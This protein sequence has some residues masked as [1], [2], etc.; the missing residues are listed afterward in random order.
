MQFIATL[1][2]AFPHA[3]GWRK[4]WRQLLRWGLGFGLRT[5]LFPE[6]YRVQLG[7]V[8]GWIKLGPGGA[9]S[10]FDRAMVIEVASICNASCSFC[11]YPLLEFPRKVMPAAAFA[12][13][14]DTARAAGLQDVDFTPYL[15]EAFVDPQFIPRIRQAR[16]ALPTASLRVTT[17]ATLLT[18]FDLDA[19]L[20]SGITHIYVSFGAWGREDYLKLYQ[21]DAWD[22]VLA[23]IQQLLAAKQRLRSAVEIHLWYRVLDAARIRTHPDNLALLAR[24]Q[25]AINHV[26]YVDVFHDILAISGQ[27]SEHIRIERQFDG[28][29]LKQLPCAHLGKL[30][31]SATGK[32]FCC[33][34][35]ASD[36]HRQEQSWFYLAEG[37]ATLPDLNAALAQKVRQW[38]NGELSP[39][40]RTCPVYIPANLAGQT[41]AYPTPPAG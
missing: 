6:K 16:A 5:G 40:C 21:I 14:L 35:A 11:S 29:A 25:D 37:A 26:D 38:E 18:R 27:Q 20:A 7:R 2:S 15:G 4:L 8:H 39:C 12:R 32:W 22:N 41:I 33:Y 19:L 30:A 28:S 23:G 34:C 1:V 31:H 36:C 24:F 13:A 3:P 10:P 9:A 17:N